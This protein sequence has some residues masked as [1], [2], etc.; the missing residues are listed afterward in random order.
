MNH[1]YFIF[2]FFFI[3]A[4]NAQKHDQIWITGYTLSGDGLQSLD[5]KTSPPTFSPHGKSNLLY[6]L[7][8][9]STFFSDSLGQQLQFWS[10]GFEVFDRDGEFVENGKQINRPSGIIFDYEPYLTNG[11]LIISIPDPSKPNHAYLIYM[12]LNYN[13]TGT[14][15]ILTH[16]FYARID[17]AANQG[18]G[19]VIEKD[20]VLLTGD[21]IRPSV[22]K[23]SN[24]RDW[25]LVL[26]QRTLPGYYVYLFDTTGVKGPLFDQTGFVF[27][28]PQSLVDQTIFT[29]NGKNFI[30]ATSKKGIILADFDRCKGDITNT[31][32]LPLSDSALILDM[33]VSHDSRFLF[34]NVPFYLLRYDLKA[35]SQVQQTLDTIAAYDGSFE[36]N[37]FY[38]WFFQQTLA[39]DQKIYM[40]PANGSHYH[41]VIHK[42]ET[43]VQSFDF[44]QRALTIPIWSCATLPTYANYRLAAESVPC[45]AGALPQLKPLS[46]FDNG[47]EGLKSQTIKKPETRAYNHFLQTGSGFPNLPINPHQLYRYE[48]N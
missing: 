43:P 20:V 10:N 18:K 21:L 24:G 48:K 35:G 33:A 12:S 1:Y 26:G 7:G 38:H 40:S 22:V 25:W 46:L 32:V 16:A 28:N 47:S 4:L 6:E 19:K 29:P 31:R 37:N 23:H 15:R 8:A 30:R 14:D 42:P 34:V 2:Y 44:E 17:M 39:P 41:H 36:F 11:K 5:F 27:N 3:A 13:D 9:N 45:S